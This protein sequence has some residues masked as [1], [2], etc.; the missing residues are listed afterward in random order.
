MA[1]D[2]KNKDVASESFYEVCEFVRKM[3]AVSPLIPA[4]PAG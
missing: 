4:A 3:C 2:R 1:A